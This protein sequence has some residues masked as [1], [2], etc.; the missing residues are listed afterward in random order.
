MAETP[1]LFWHN[2]PL[3]NHPRIN[4]N[5]HPFRFIFCVI[6][7]CLSHYVGDMWKHL[8]IS[9]LFWVVSSI[10]SYM[11]ATAMWLHT[12][13]FPPSCHLCRMQPTTM[14]SSTAYCYSSLLWRCSGVSISMALILS[15]WKSGFLISL[16][17]LLFDFIML[18][19]M[20]CILLVA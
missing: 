13:A 18:L 2:C 16:V 8:L 3:Y 7:C 11:H 10:F 1:V 9:V 4:L 6:W 12:V 17:F 19:E 14:A 5:S 15:Y 20:L